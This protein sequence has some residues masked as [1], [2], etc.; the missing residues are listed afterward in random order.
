[1]PP[2][3]LAWVH[4]CFASGDTPAEIAEAS[5]RT[6]S[7]ILAHLPTIQITEHE[8][9]VLGLYAAGC[10][11]SQIDQERGIHN[12]RYPGSAALKCIGRLRRKGVPI[13]HRRPDLV[14]QG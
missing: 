3:E 6:L 9:D 10:R 13:P 12:P 7:E 14:P 11:L 1:L 4:E 5:G 2:D 8:R